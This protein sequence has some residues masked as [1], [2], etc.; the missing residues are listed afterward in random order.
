MLIP[1]KVIANKILDKLTYRISRLL[2]RRKNLYVPERC[3]DSLPAR[4]INHYKSLDIKRKS[5]VFENQSNEIEYERGCRPVQPQF[6]GFNQ[7][8]ELIVRRI[9]E[10]IKYIEDSPI[11]KAEAFEDVLYIPKYKSFYLLSNGSRVSTFRKVFLPQS[12]Q[13]S[14]GFQSL[15]NQS[16]DISKIKRINQKFIYGDNLSIDYGHFLVESISRLWYLEKLDKLPILVTG[17]PRKLKSLLR[18]DFERNFIDEFMLSLGLAADQ[19]IELTKPVILK[20]IVIPYPSFKAGK[21]EVFADHKTIP[22]L[23]T[24]RLLPDKISRTDQPLYISRV[25]LTRKNFNRNIIGEDKLE[26]ILRDKNFAIAYPEELTLKQQ[27]YLINKH[28]VII[29][30]WG[31]SLHTIL[32]DISGK[33]NLVCISDD[34]FINPNFFLFDAVKSISSIYIPALRIGQDNQKGRYS[35]FNRLLD[36]D[37]VLSGLKNFNII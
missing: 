14:P 15:S 10:S 25:K 6:F 11:N 17:Q 30:P 5:L 26:D 8:N 23:V 21:R 12:V 24:Q 7:H 20:E 37:L 31:S 2:R 32:F 4:S 1:I 16:I 13:E 27:I 29:G 34:C 36:V 33:K 19:F 18:L 22:E 9:Y 28:N 3:S 35:N